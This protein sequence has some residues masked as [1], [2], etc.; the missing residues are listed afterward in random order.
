MLKHAGFWLTDAELESLF[1]PVQPIKRKMAC[2]AT[3]GAATT[4]MGSAQSAG[5]TVLMSSVTMGLSA[6]SLTATAVE[7]APLTNVTIARSG[8]LFGTLFAVRIF[9]M[10]AVACVLLTVPAA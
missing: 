3:L 4:T 10:S 1:R 5:R 9:I 8:A 7:L 2:F 6:T